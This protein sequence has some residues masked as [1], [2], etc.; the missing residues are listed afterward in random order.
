[1]HC[2]ITQYCYTIVVCITF[3]STHS[4]RSDMLRTHF[5][6]CNN[7]PPTKGCTWLVMLEP[8][9]FTVSA[10]W[11]VLAWVPSSFSLVHRIVSLKLPPNPHSKAATEAWSTVSERIY[12]A[13]VDGLSSLLNKH[14]A[15]TAARQG[16][17]ENFQA[18]FLNNVSCDVHTW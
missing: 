4:H 14:K 12:T 3:N 15:L 13:S 18:A 2:A 9:S 6:N 11:K 16:K 1:M 17:V 7:I 5:R 10:H 8:V